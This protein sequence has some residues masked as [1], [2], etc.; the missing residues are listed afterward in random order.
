MILSDDVSDD[1]SIDDGTESDGDYVEPRE[2]DSEGAGNV[3]RIV[4][5]ALK[6]TWT[7]Q[8][9]IFIKKD[10]NSWSKVKSPTHIRSRWQN[11]LTKLAGVI[12]Q[13][14]KAIT[15]F[16]T[17]NGPLLTYLLHGAEPFLRS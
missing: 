2:G 6:W 10:R 4:T 13:T 14:K 1:D 15:P 8:I 5:A 12:D 7:L 3:R 9:T 17:R 11:I 16:K